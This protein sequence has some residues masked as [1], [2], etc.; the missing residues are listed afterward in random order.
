MAS[1]RI[2]FD[3]WPGTQQFR[4][5][6]TFD[7]PHYA[8]TTRLDA[9]ALKKRGG[10]PFRGVLWALGA[11]LA[12]V[13][14]MRLRFEGD[15]VTLHDEV[16]ISPPIALDDG[17][18]AY[19]YFDWTPDRAAFD[20][21]AAGVI[22][23]V[24]RSGSLDPTS[25]K[26]CVTFASCLPWLDFTALDNA[27]PHSDDCVPRLAWG[28]IVPKGDG[29]DMA[30]SVQVHHALVAGRDIGAFMDAVQAALDAA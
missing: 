3:D 30:V 28:K 29:F 17:S 16:Q 13:D 14:A 1:R 19:G 25:G 27:M 5:F 9:A 12:S 23:T 18:F 7:R 4:F 22:E 21:H 11:G 15:V 26:P 10:S 24:R 2:D 8:I 6:R 20:A